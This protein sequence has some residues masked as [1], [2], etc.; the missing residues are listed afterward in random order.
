MDK[1]ELEGKRSSFDGFKLQTLKDSRKIAGIDGK[2]AL[3]TYKDGSSAE[4]VYATDWEVDGFIF[5]RF[6][7]IKQLPILFDYK[8]EDGSVTHFTVER[9]VAKPVET[10]SFEIPSNYKLLSPKEFAQMKKT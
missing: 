5:E 6:P 3:I 8:N 7:G 4:I 1:D 10:S 9:I 2:E